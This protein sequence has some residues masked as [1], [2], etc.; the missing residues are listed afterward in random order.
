MSRLIHFTISESLLNR[1]IYSTTRR[2]DYMPRASLSGLAKPPTSPEFD[3]AL[4]L[5]FETYELTLGDYVRTYY[6]AKWIRKN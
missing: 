6:G 1:V 5:V 2:S 3:P 4:N